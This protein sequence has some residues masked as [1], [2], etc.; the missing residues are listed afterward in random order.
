MIKLRFK[1]FKYPGLEN[2]L[3]GVGKFIRLFGEIRFKTRNDEWHKRESAIIDTGAPISM[4]PQD[5]WESIET[6]IL[7]DHEAYGIN[8]CKE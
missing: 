3:E 2:K 8:P 6:E 1:E 5:L 7:T 4:M